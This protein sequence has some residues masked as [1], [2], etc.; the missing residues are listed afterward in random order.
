MA[1]A[2]SMAELKVAMAARE[3]EILVTDEGLAGRI[4]MWNVL[5]TVA[6]IL[7]VVVLA[8]GIFAWANPMRIP[9]LEQ[10]WALLTRRIMLGM[11]VLLLF[12]D[13]VL[14]VVRAYKP[15]AGVDGSLKLVPRKAS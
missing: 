9:E 7:V 6:N 11:G 2:G 13:Y 15:V 5:R 10:D 8:L 12:A 4:R 1:S 3:A 14:P